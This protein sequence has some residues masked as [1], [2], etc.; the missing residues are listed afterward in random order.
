MRSNE[1]IQQNY[2]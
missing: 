1:I 2:I